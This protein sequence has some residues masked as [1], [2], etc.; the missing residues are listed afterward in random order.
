MW[1][2]VTSGGWAEGKVFELELFAIKERIAAKEDSRTSAAKSAPLNPSARGSF[3][4]LSKSTD[5]CHGVLRPQVFK[6]SERSSGD[7][8]RT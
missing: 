2:A 4:T 7:G 3:A 5:G 6:I 8:K 1:S